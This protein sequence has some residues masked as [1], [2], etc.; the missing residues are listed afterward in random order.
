MASSTAPLAARNVFSSKMLKRTDYG[1]RGTQ[2]A[3]VCRGAAIRLFNRLFPLGGEPFCTGLA[4]PS[5]LHG[6]ARAGR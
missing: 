6:R 4:V 3:P 1:I 5:Q 2:L